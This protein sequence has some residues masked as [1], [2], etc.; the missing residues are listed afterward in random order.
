MEKFIKNV[1]TIIALLLCIIVFLGNVIFTSTVSYDWVENVSYNYISIISTI[2]VIAIIV[3]IMS[4]GN[5][6]KEKWE[7]KLSIKKR[8]IILAIIFIIYV[9]I[10]IFWIFIRNSYP[11]ADSLYVYDAA[12][13]MF[14][15]KTISQLKYFELY[16]QNLSLAYVFSKIFRILG[17]SNVLIIKFINVIAN[18][19][20]VIGLYMITKLLNEKYEVNKSLL[21]ILSFTYIP[22]IL[23]VN[24]TYGDLISL[25]FAIFSMFFAMMYVKDSKYRYI[26]MSVISVAVSV[27]LRMNNLIFVIAIVIY[28]GLDLLSNVKLKVLREN[29]LKIL[30]KTVVII[31]FIAIAILPSITVKDVLI[32]R[33]ALDEDK[34]FP[35][36]GFIAMGMMEGTRA[37]GWY[38]DTCAQIGWKNIENADDEYKI[39]IQDRLKGFSNNILKMGKFYIKKIVSMWSEPLNESIWQNLSFNFGED[40]SEPRSEEEIEESNKLDEKLTNESKI[41]ETYQKALMIIIFFSVI[42]LII[43]NRKNITN[44]LI[45]LLLCFIGGFM[46]HCLW[47]AKSRYIIPYIIAVIPLASIESSIKREEVK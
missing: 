22:I 39:I 18:I 15:G 2:V 41:F 12:K 21:G 26:V 25:P 28:L 3:G 29:Y 34:K 42:R 35:T 7:S 36:A 32:N 14:E 19:F 1:I 20:T 11:I 43:K 8:R 47:E 45:L 10:Q 17:S 13:E 4:T 30:L 27:I 23:L 46:F 44:E 38:H 5:F 31:L 24:F 37:N 16:P 40:K 6:I 33:Y 9:A